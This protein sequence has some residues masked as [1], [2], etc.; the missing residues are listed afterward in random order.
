[1]LP[2]NLG[3]KRIPLFN[4]LFVCIKILD[5]LL[6]YS[7]QTKLLSTQIKNYKMSV[8][9]HHAMYLQSSDRNT[10]QQESKF[11]IQVLSGAPGKDSFLYLHTSLLT[12]WCEFAQATLKSCR[13]LAV[14]NTYKCCVRSKFNSLSAF[15]F[16]SAQNAMH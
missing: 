1:M 7:I 9:L 11:P 8:L 15:F 10:R 5:K 3:C 6:Q 14:H 4:D 2:F 13:R 16:G 12:P